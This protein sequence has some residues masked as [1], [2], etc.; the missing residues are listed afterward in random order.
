MDHEGMGHTQSFIIAPSLT[1]IVVVT[2]VPRKKSLCQPW[3]LSFSLDFSIS[4]TL[5]TSMWLYLFSKYLTSFDIMGTLGNIG[6]RICRFLVGSMLSP[7]NFLAGGN[8]LPQFVVSQFALMSSVSSRTLNSSTWPCRMVVLIFLVTFCHAS[9]G[10]SNTNVQKQFYS[11]IGHVGIDSIVSAVVEL[12]RE[13]NIIA[14]LIQ[15]HSSSLM[16]IDLFI[17]TREAGIV[18]VCFAVR[19]HNYS[20]AIAVPT[21][22]CVW[23]KIFSQFAIYAEYTTS[24][25]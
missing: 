23:G 13:H 10:L 2:S 6:H 7:P 1:T 17:T 3:N 16:T 8:W 11:V 25:T 21:F 24:N 14:S 15:F 22:V 4:H 9:A 5:C 18:F 19:R 12:W 20:I